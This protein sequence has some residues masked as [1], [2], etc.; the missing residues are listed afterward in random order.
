MTNFVS[1]LLNLFHG[2]AKRGLA[3][4]GYSGGMRERRG[5]GR[6]ENERLKGQVSNREAQNVKGTWRS[7]EEIKEWESSII[8]ES[9]GRW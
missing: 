5:G 6:L 2:L 4:S 7:T 8:W 3:E 9:S 1:A